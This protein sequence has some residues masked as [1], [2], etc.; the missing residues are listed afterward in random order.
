MLVLMLLSVVLFIDTLV[1]VVAAVAVSREEDGIDNDDAGNGTGCNGT[2]NGTDISDEIGTSR[3][4][5]VGGVM[6]VLV[7]AIALMLL[8]LLLLLLL[9]E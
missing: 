2:G 6:L 7:M 8:L 5:A 1:A 9:L 3:V 4:I